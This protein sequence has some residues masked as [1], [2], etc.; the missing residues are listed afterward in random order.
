MCKIAT[1]RKYPTRTADADSVKA[2]HYMVFHIFYIIYCIIVKSE[3]YLFHFF[4]LMRVQHLRR[5]FRALP[6]SSTMS[7]RLR[8]SPY[9][10]LLEKENVRVSSWSIIF[11]TADFYHFFCN[12]TLYVL[13]IQLII[14]DWTLDRKDV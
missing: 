11:S 2:I 8:P 14:V 9:K 7:S 10:K 5:F 12:T 6:A 13:H 4:Y 1:L 3:I